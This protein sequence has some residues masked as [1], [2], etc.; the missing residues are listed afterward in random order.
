MSGMGGFAGALLTHPLDT[1]K[2]HFQYSR[3]FSLPNIRPIEYFNGCTY[4]CS[5]SLISMGIGWTV[6]SYLGLKN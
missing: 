1:L 2:T 6:Y 5:I 4:R 3:S